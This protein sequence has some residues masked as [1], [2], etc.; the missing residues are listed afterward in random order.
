[1]VLF[2]AV[3]SGEDPDSRESSEHTQVPYKKQG[4]H[5]R[6]TRHRIRADSPDHD[7]VQHIHKIRDAVLKHDRQSDRHSVTNKFPVKNRSHI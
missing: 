6:D 2:P 3:L 1:M 5:D 7:I 4:V